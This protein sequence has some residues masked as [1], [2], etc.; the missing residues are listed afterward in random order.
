M[1]IHLNE[2]GL[3]RWQCDEGTATDG[4]LAEKAVADG[5]DAED[6]AVDEAPAD[7]AIEGS[8]EQGQWELIPAE[9]EED[10][11]AVLNMDPVEPE[12]M[13]ESYSALKPPTKRRRG[14][15]RT[16]PAPSATVC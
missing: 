15:P 2:F 8:D 3:W 16:P 13:T 5:L 12:A 1:G 4:A 14:R 11:F 9:T 6:T 7:G 10:I